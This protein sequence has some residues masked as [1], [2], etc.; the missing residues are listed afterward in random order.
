MPGRS[1][2]TLGSTI[3]GLPLNPSPLKALL[4]TG[5]LTAVPISTLADAKL[6]GL[7]SPTRIRGSFFVVFKSGA[8]LASVAHAGP[9]APTL[10]PQLV[11]TSEY[12][13]RRL[14]V[15]LCDQIH[16]EFVGFS[17][18]PGYAAFIV[19]K[20]SDSAVRDVLAKDPRISEIGANFPVHY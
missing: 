8:D 7:D 13:A 19:H 18:Y 20:A 5:L 6:L 10:L 9:I 3:D 12:A 2:S 17:Y 15:A 4:V 14:A 16:A 1:S 11:P